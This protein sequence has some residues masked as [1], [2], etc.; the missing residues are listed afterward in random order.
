MLST[1]WRLESYSFPLPASVLKIERG[2]P[3]SLRMR[4]RIDTLAIRKAVV[5]LEWQRQHLQP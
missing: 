2:L 1:T 3:D 5:P 4:N